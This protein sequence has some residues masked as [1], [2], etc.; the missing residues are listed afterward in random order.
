MKTFYKYSII[1]IDKISRIRI[2]WK[3]INYEK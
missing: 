3:D 2:I 1:A